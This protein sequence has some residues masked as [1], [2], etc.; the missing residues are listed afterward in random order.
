MKKTPALSSQKSIFRSVSVRLRYLR[1]APRKV[2]LVAHMIKKLPVNEAQA[3]LTM[4]GR[5]SAQPILKLL[6]SAL[7][8]AKEKSISSEKLIIKDI[9]VDKGPMLKRWMPR[10]QGR[11][12]P[13]HKVSS[14]I[15]LVLEE[16]EKERPSRFVMESK[17][18]AK[19]KE[20]KV[21][22]EKA[23]PRHADEEKKSE[24]KTEIKTEAKTQEK[25]FVKKLFQRKSV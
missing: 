18:E 12:T 15:T 22:E 16:S 6:I 4:H 9:R 7:A 13:I 19:K 17:K 25:G 23:A 10:A 5:R 8:A 14:H 3:Q 20:K 1:I 21:K 11:A 24:K 2:R